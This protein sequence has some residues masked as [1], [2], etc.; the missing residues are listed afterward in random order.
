MLTERFC[1]RM[2]PADLRCVDVVAEHLRRPQRLTF[3]TR[4]DA[5]RGAVRAYASIIGG[6]TVAG[7]TADGNDPDSPRQ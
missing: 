5:F 1:V 6:P 7:L 3:P 2:S 4:S